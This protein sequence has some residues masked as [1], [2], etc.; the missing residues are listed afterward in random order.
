M[1]KKNKAFKCRLYPSKE[2]MQLLRKTFGCV[3]FTYLKDMIPHESA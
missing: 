1:A 3:S 2:Q